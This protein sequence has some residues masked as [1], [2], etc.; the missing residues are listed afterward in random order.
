[1]TV[2]PWWS[3]RTRLLACN[4]PYSAEMGQTAGPP[5][6]ASAGIDSVVQV[7]CGET[8]ARMCGGIKSPL[9]LLWF[10]AF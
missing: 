8:V 10:E 4:G 7:R 6:G 2:W 1:M 9:N 3:R 5:A